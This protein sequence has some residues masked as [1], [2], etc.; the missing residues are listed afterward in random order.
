VGARIVRNLALPAVAAVVLALAAAPAFAAPADPGP[1]HHLTL[2]LRPA[3]GSVL[4]SA[5]E[6]SSVSAALSAR[7][8]TVGTIQGLALPVSGSATAVRSTFAA[9]GAP[10]DLGGAATAVKAAY[11]ATADPIMM[12]PRVT[13]RPGYGGSARGGSVTGA[14][15]RS[16]YHA[17]TISEPMASPT[18]TASTPIIATIQLSGWDAGNLT[19]FAQHPEYSQ[20]NSRIYTSTTYDP[21]TSGQYTGV[22]VNGATLTHVTCTG[23]D[24]E[25]ALDQ[26]ALLTA[27]PTL[28]QRAY[29]APN[30]SGSSMLAAFNAVLTDVTT[31]HRP[32]VAVST[33]WG[34]C[35]PDLGDM[36]HSS[37]V[38]SMESVLSSLNS[39]GVTVF[40]ASG[41]SGDEDCG[42]GDSTLSV[43]YPASSP[44]VVGV[45]G[46]TFQS[47]SA[48]TAWDTGQDEATGGGASSHFIAPGWQQPVVGAGSPR[49]VPDVAMDADP[50]TGL[51]IR[52]AGVWESA[53]GTSLA[54]PLMAG[55]IANLV[56]G[57][58]R[59]TGLGDIHPALYAHTGDFTDVVTT[60]PNGTSPPTSYVQPTATCYDASSGLGTPNLTLLNTDLFGGSSGTP[61]CAGQGSVIFSGAASTAAPT[62]SPGPEPAPA[63]T[64]VVGTP[65]VQ[66]TR[67]AL[68]SKAGTVNLS[69]VS[70]DSTA[71]V[72]GFAVSVFRADGS[73]AGSDSLG[74]SIGSLLI[75]APGGTAYTVVIT[76]TDST[77]VTASTRTKP[78][79]IPLDDRS[80]KRSAG[81]SSVHKAGSLASTLSSSAK[82][83]ATAT[84]TLDGSRFTVLYST[85]PA[86][87]SFQVLVDGKVVKTVATKGKSRNQVTVTVSA[88]TGSHRVV[89]RVLKAKKGK[90]GPVAL[91]GFLAS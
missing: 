11:D 81:W 37:Y 53:G 86:G 61:A 50:D 35:E 87:G 17:A 48:D 32:I 57:H 7:G 75:S 4:P 72:T 90:T 38:S 82:P 73:L 40:A 13:F 91:D 25:V 44:N 67:W 64:P 49:V 23:C 26:E 24:D 79:S 62:P 78:V 6:V 29:I 80:S 76:A 45:G 41:D 85:A 52:S 9:S 69:W 12:H 71:A 33:S 70:A 74:P 34:A 18:F 14:N 5:A 47:P 46:T 3:P 83:G 89:V 10:V 65:F 27:A 51:I 1:T 21:T 16:A 59:T 20:A 22:A 63:A 58:G 55:L 88:K 39:A 2:T 68:G 43:D 56:N 30:T 8:L 42:S 60:T 84:V 15:I 54:A 77:G 28:A 36:T 66:V 19:Y 31:N